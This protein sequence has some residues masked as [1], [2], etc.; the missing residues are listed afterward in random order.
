MLH[1]PAS[2]FHSLIIFIDG[3]QFVKKMPNNVRHLSTAAEYIRAQKTI[4]LSQ[5]QVNSVVATIHAAALP[6]GEETN[7]LHRAHVEKLRAAAALRPAR[8]GAKPYKRYP[9]K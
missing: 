9:S 3:S 7:K 2:A 1:L 5:A 8:V 6:P 4:H